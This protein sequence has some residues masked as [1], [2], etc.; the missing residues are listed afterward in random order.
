MTQSATFITL[1][2]PACIVHD[3]STWPS[4]STL[5]FIG[6]ALLVARRDEHG[7]WSIGIEDAVVGPEFTREQAFERLAD[8]LPAAPIFVGW[9]LGRLTIDPLLDLARDLPEP[10]RH[11][12]PARLARATRGLV[13]DMAQAQSETAALPARSGLQPIGN[14]PAE[15][16]S[17]QRHR[18]LMSGVKHK[19]RR[20]LRD[21]A[22]ALW[23]YWLRSAPKGVEGA[24]A[25]TQALLAGDAA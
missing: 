16:V 7:A 10:L 6:Y 8:I 2:A 18:D 4:T 12:F 25:V 11:H 9:E 14:V 22:L 3:C 1:A 21:E 19:V 17:D 24:L 15:L 5:E 23:R 13:V 20:A